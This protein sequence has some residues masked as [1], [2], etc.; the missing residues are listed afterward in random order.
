MSKTPE[1]LP[2]PCCKSNADYEFYLETHDYYVSCAGCGLTTLATKSKKE[3]AEL[4]NTRA[5]LPEVQ[6]AIERDTPKKPTHQHDGDFAKEGFCPKCVEDVDSKWN[7]EICEY[8][9][10][11]LDWSQS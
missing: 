6:S 2:C 5:Y 11:R 3:A 4:W 7:D 8:C 9:G 1:L 10:Q